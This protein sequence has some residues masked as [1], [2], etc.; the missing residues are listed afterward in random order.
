MG[1]ELSGLTVH[2]FSARGP[3]FTRRS[4]RRCSH[5]ADKFSRLLRGASSL[6][7]TGIKNPRDHTIIRPHV[8]NRRT[9]CKRLQS[10]YLSDML[11]WK[12]RIEGIINGLGDPP[13]LFSQKTIEKT[14][15]NQNK[16]ENNRKQ[17]KTTRKTEKNKTKNRKHQKKTEKNRKPP[18]FPPQTVDNS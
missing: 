6:P 1:T 8:E 14:R 11:G 17:Q 15:K 5:Q 10:D 4:L 7:K 18:G 3:D 12:N 2:G 16:I 13:G 9:S